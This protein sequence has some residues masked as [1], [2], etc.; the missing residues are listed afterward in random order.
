MTNKKQ[1]HLGAFFQ[2]FLGHHLA[3][4]RYPETKTEEVTSLS[5]YKE[6]AQ[7]AEQG[8]FDLLF[9]ADVLAHNE[10][11]IAYTPQIRLE[12]TSVMAA[13]AG[14]T[15][16]IG[17]VATLSTTFNHPF[18][19]A[20]K[21][22]TIDHMSAGRSAWNIVTTAHDHEAANFGLEHIIDHSLRYEKADE[23]VEVTK[24]LWDSW[25]DDTLLFNRETGIFLDASKIHPINHEGKYYKVRGPINI[26]R[27]P[28]G[29]PVLVTA[30][31]SE[32]GK[33]FAAKHAD[34]LFTIAP[35]TVAEGKVIYDDMKQRVAKYG[36]NP[37]H[38]NIM[39]GIVPFVAKTQ[40]EAEEKYEAFQELI[41]PEL[42]IGWLSRY[43]DHDLSQYSPDD[44]M[45][46]LKNSKDVNGEKGRFELLSDLAKKENWTIRQLANYFVRGQGHLFVV[47][48]GELVADTL[49]DWFLNGAA[50][51]F[52][53]KFPY[54]PGG[55]K[56][57]VDYT[58][59][60]LQERGLFRTEYE[61][62]T[63]RE[64]LGLDFPQVK[65][66]INV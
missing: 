52:N 21:F 30:S 10:E 6:I 50:D 48:S 3:A 34:I 57:F 58:I 40:K 18:N 32:D 16:K 54:F 64:N 20:R 55:V 53:V 13:L 5:L 63:L 28:Q 60:V 1:M 49:S 26:P 39:P 29:H 41:L 2:T 59:P 65:R 62:S 43:V 37:D 17:L 4:W 22:A 23:F 38:L 14:V 25:E 9:L 51:G 47:G 11:D 12:A 46:E 8:K 33:E 27:P 19:V 36:R 66:S 7:L 56:D 42:G 35:S 31:A 61:G 24:E 45:P 44:P 15:D